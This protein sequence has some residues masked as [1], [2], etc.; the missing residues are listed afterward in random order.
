MYVPTAYAGIKTAFYYLLKNKTANIFFHV[1]ELF[2]I[3]FINFIN[4]SIQIAAFESQIRLI[5]VSLKF[6]TTKTL[7]T[8]KNNSVFELK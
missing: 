5:I 6:M 7:C 8:T 4:V 1:F 2:S 3:T